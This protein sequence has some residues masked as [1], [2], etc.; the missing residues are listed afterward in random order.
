MQIYNFS[1]S[2]NFLVFLNLISE[3]WVEIYSFFSAISLMW[4]PSFRARCYKWMID[5]E[6]I[7]VSSV[8]V[9]CSSCWM[10]WNTSSWDAERLPS[11]GWTATK[12][13]L[14]ILLPQLG[15]AVMRPERSVNILPACDGFV[16]SACGSER[17]MRRGSEWWILPGRLGVVVI[18]S[19]FCL[20]ASFSADYIILSDYSLGPDAQTCWRLQCN[21]TCLCMTCGCYMRSGSARSVRAVC[22]A[23]IVTNQSRRA[24]YQC[25]SK[26]PQLHQEPMQFPDNLCAN[27]RLSC[28][29]T[30][31][32]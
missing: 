22:L 26:S 10:Q 25:C 32:I 6:C 20:T 17:V 19:S 9:A 12:S 23:L 5:Y 27:Q 31:N 16:F 24:A 3:F 2:Q 1:N 14:L 21:I 13:R 7:C 28:C 18:A 11:S 29:L 30:W 15:A 8:C 4:H